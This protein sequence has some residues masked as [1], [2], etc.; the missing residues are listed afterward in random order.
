MLNKKSNQMKTLTYLLILFFVFT[1][2]KKEPS[3]SF[4]ATGNLKAGQS[5]TFVNNSAHASLYEWN[6]GDGETSTIEAPTHIYKKPGGYKVILTAEGDEGS[7]TASKTIN[8][9]GTTFSF[10]NNTSFDLHK[11]VS[12]FYDGSDI[13]DLFQ[14]GTLL[15]GKETEPVVSERAEIMGGFVENTVVFIL[16]DPYLL[17]KDMHNTFVITD[18]SN[19]YSGKGNLNELYIKAMSGPSSRIN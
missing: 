19:V 16:T 8:V 5:I 17:V 10:I 6:F 13:V 14:Y 4:E 3:A 12:Y 11:F 2:C 1:S 7:S 9:T 15:K 18:E